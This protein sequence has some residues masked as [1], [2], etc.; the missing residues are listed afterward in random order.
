MKL[1]HITPVQR[2]PTGAP[3]PSPACP[4]CDARQG[5]QAVMFA[6]AEA[7]VVP[8]PRS[9]LPRD[10]ELAV[11]HLEAADMIKGVRRARSCPSHQDALETGDVGDTR[12]PPAVT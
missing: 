7:G 12:R 4:L 8:Q 9:E 1:R 6:A 5:E 3:L 11:E 2:P 10:R